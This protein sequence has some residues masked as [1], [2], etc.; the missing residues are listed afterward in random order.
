[1]RQSLTVLVVVAILALVVLVTVKVPLSASP[2]RV[3]AL[4]LRAGFVTLFNDGTYTAPCG[5]GTLPMGWTAFVYQ[6]NRSNVTFH[7]AGAWTASR[8]TEVEFGLWFNIATTDDLR[9]W[10][11]FSHCNPTIPMP[12]PSPPPNAPPPIPPALPY[13]GSVDDNVTTFPEATLFVLVFRSFDGGDT[14][15]VTEPFTVAPV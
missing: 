3:G 1:M 11:P 2:I 14:I 10:E 8:P 15:E 5:G 9:N 12:P 13:S 4:P 6:S 7:L